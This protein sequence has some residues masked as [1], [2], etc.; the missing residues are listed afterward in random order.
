MQKFEKE[1]KL[2]I[3]TTIED[4]IC[5]STS[6]FIIH[7]LLMKN[8]FFALFLVFTLSACTSQ[9]TWTKPI[10]SSESRT[11]ATPTF[12]SGKHVVE[13][14]A[15][16]QCPACINFAKT[17]APIIEWYAEKWQLTIVYRQ[18]PLNSIHK[19]ANRDAIAALCAQ[20]QEKYLDYKKALYA[21]EETKAGASVSDEDR[22]NAAKDAGLDATWMQACLAT[23][24][25][26][27]QVESD[28]AYGNSIR[29]EGTPSV[30][31]DGKKLDFTVF[32]DTEMFTKFLDRVVSE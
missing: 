25:Y 13:L 8:I 3:I 24:R 7:F 21:L 9:D 26:Q 27:A 12:G 28:V 19:N 6:R 14:F 4:C 2:Y 11:V 29:V 32:R 17:I 1:S 23:D 16:F 20:E 31:L 22:V 18:F 10:V 30:F 5:Q 15:D